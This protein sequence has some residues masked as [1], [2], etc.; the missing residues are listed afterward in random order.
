MRS[1]RQCQICDK[2]G[3]HFG[4]NDM[5][6]VEGSICLGLLRASDRGNRYDPLLGI[7]FV[8]SENWKKFEVNSNR[9]P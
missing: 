6:E 2:E 5:S 4:D 7:V 1:P 8:Y 3:T 9:A